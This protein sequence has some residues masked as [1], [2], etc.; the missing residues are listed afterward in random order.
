M[1]NKN[2]QGPVRHNPE[3]NLWVIVRVQPIR[4]LAEMG[5]GFDSQSTKFFKYQEI[6]PMVKKLAALGMNNHQIAVQ[7][8]VDWKTV[9]KVQQKYFAN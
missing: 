9:S 7:L 2:G 6:A 3:T 5:F 1:L 8:Q 4:T